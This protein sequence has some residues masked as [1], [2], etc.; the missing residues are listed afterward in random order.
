MKKGFIY[1]LSFL[2]CLSSH[3]QILT[4]EPDFVTESGSIK[5]V[6]DASQGS[7]GLMNYNGD[8]Y[9]HTGV[10][11]GSNDSRWEYASTWGVNS[12]K[13]KMASLGNNKWELTLSPDIRTYYG[14]PAGTP[15]KKL[16]FVFRSGAKSG[17]DYL[18]G[19]ETGDKDIYL[20]VY[21]SG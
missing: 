8:V 6:F 9:A 17:N 16:V 18:T 10:I 2:F 11:T 3:A 20:S 14:V 19:K 15:I 13:Y 1:I 21:E 5:V 4:T 7:K 12:D